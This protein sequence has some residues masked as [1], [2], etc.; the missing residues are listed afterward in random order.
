VEVPDDWL[1][2]GNDWEVPRPEL[3]YSIGFGGHVSCEGGHRHW[4]PE[5]WLVAQAYDFIVPAH[6]SERVSTLRQWH[7]VAADNIDF[8][9]FCQGDYTTAARHKVAADVL[10]W[11]LY[12]DDSTASGRELRL[13]QEAFLVSASLQDVLAR[14]IQERGSL[15]QLSLRNAI[16]LN[17]THPALAPA[18]LMRL[19]LDDHGLTWEDAWRM[20]QQC[21]SYTNHTLMPEALETWDLTLFG[22][23]LPRHLEIIY[24]INF[25]FLAS[26]KE[27]FPGDDALLARVSII[28]ETGSRRVRM[29]A[30]AIIASHKV[31]GVS[32]LHS[33]LMVQTIFADYARIFPDRFHNV[34]NGVTPRRWLMQANP[35]LSTLLDSAIGREWRHDLTGLAAL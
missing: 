14:H 10:N 6:N 31:N 16:H 1:R 25:R 35:A 8:A 23:L 5:Q 11:V 27:R 33:D 15:Q 32:A 30:L 3:R 21:V 34:T 13:K 17:D 26:V 24:E 19:L 18:E 9:A 22:R 28:D 4:V 2:L 20:T 29:A 7:A 12:P